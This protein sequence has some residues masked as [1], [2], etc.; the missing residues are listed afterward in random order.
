LIFLV[1]SCY[2]LILQTVQLLQIPAACFHKEITQGMNPKPE[3]F[4]IQKTG[5]ERKK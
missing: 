4:Q 3:I 2:A 5:K 1:L